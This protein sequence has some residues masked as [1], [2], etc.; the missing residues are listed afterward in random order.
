MADT[1]LYLLY[2]IA[3]LASLSCALSGSLLT[4]QKKAMLGDAISHSSLLGLVLAYII[5]GERSIPYMLLG[6]LVA[7]ISTAYITDKLKRFLRIQYDAALGVIFT[8]SF[9]VAVILISQYTRQIHLDQHFVLFGEIALAPFDT[10]LFGDTDIGPRAIWTLSIALLFNITIISLGWNRIKATL[11][12]TNLIQAMGINSRY[13]QQICSTLVA[14]TAVSAFESVGAIL[15]V[16]LL[17]IPS[18]TAKLF[19]NNSLIKH[20]TLSLLFAFIATLQGILLAFWLDTAIAA[21]IATTLF[22]NFI[23]LSLGK[24]LYQNQADGKTVTNH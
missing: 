24:T 17:V 6:A 9:A 19:I 3:L 22:I 10:I 13:W 12:A 23:M 5:S 4:V 11:F 21:T 1:S 7:G 8:S 18:N 14:I 2:L 16:A 20:M 15:V